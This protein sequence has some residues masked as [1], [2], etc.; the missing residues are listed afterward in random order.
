MKI[1]FK[2]TYYGEHEAQAVHEA[3]NGK[4][5][6]P[7]ATAMLES[8]FPGRRV[9]LTTSGSAAFELLF[10]GLDL[11]PG[12]E[13]VMPSFTFPSCANAAM[14]TGLTPVF[15]DIEEATLTMDIEGAGYKITKHTA[16]VSVTHYGGSSPD[17][18]ALMQR[19][20]GRLIIEDAA[21][22]FGA[23]HRGQPLGGIADAGILSFH[24]TKSI[25]AGEGGAL[26]VDE[27]H[28]GLIERLQTIYDNGTDRAAFLRG[29]VDSYT[30]QTSGLNVAMPNLCAALLCA[31]LEREA[32]I[33]QLHRKVCDYYRA[34]L[35]EDANR[36]G[37]ALSPVQ[38]ENEDNGHVFYLLFADHTA[39]ER[40][41]MHLA[42]QG[43]AAH[44][45]YMPLH[46]SAMG[47]KLGYKPDDLPVTQRVSECLLRLPVYA[48]LTEAQ[49]AAVVSA[50]REAL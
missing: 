4:E 33:T 46:A 8:R 1:P 34:A 13:L 32:E 17:M 23:R 41:R 44:F 12:G 39:R 9:F 50:V 25:S 45:H 49:C 35:T 22:S 5:F 26:L 14:H 15:A 6:R 11:Q 21:L 29:E 18:D 27:K 36:L 30:W 20:V 43:I 37:F 48:G 42:D 7:Q 3:L 24:E 2:Q 19:C 40:V 38:P 16:C 47:A 10:A 31:Q 28:A